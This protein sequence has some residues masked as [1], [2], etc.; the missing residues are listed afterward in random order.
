[1][2]KNQSLI[3][4][5]ILFL[6]GAGIVVLALF[7]TRSGEGVKDKDVFIWVSIGLMYLIFFV[8]FF[9]SS[10][11]IGGFSVKIP[12]WTMIWL[13]S[14]LYIAASVVV[15]IVLSKQ[16]LPFNIAI[17][18]Q[19]V[20]LFLFAINVYFGYYASSHI[21]AVN[22]EEHSKK[23][24]LD[25][26]KAKAKTVSLLI[27]GLPEE[28]ESTQ[29]LLAAVF[30]DIRYLSPVDKGA[31]RELEQK[32][33]AHLDTLAQLCGSAGEGGHPLFEAAVQKLITCVKTRKLLRN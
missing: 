24:L 15:I 7:L 32:I 3:F 17:I 8:P 27:S 20:L 6:A 18:I 9:F 2:T 4:K 13:G 23:Q 14:I 10:I 21:S 25:D 33:N 19:A 31:G 5:A 11:S 12:R 16:I 30:E 26:I 22:M 1:M 29:C 28:Y